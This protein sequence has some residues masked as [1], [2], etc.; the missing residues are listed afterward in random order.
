[1]SSIGALTIHL[2]EAKFTRDCKTVRKMDPYGLFSLRGAEETWKSATDERGSTKP[3]WKEQHHTFDIKY[4]GDDFS[5]RFFDD[6]PGKDEEICNA[7][8]KVAALCESPETDMWF[9]CFWKSKDVGKFHLKATWVPHDNKPSADEQ[10]AAHQSD[11]ERA[12]AAIAKLAARKK[13]LEAEWEEVQK[14]LEDTKDAVQ[15][16]RDNLVHC[17]CDEEHDAAIA[18]ADEDH[19]KALERIEHNKAMALQKKE[20]Y[21]AAKAAKVEK[22]EAYRDAKNAEFDAADAKADEDLAAK[23]ERIEQMKENEA[24]EHEKELEKIAAEIEA[25]K[26][27]DQEKYD[28][29]AE[30]IKEIAEKLLEYNEKMQEKL[31][32]LTML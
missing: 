10:K 11:M 19:K 32:A 22:A 28:A 25:T 7:T 9:P 14:H 13:E 23:L 24:E 12:Q 29:V 5:V 8:I 2:V 3:K 15:E 4:A 1:M 30:E 17:N 16:L 31:M 20:D 27:A 26:A 18:K 6:D 21:I